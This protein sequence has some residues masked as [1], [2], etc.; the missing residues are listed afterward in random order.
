MRST[1]HQD[2]VWVA[3]KELDQYTFAPADRPLVEKLLNDYR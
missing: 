3:V 1:V 2:Y